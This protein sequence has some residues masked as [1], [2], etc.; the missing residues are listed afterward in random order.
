[1]DKNFYETKE[2]AKKTM[3]SIDKEAL[4]KE[5]EQLYAKLTATFEDKE[6]FRL[7][8]ELLETEIELEK[9]CNQ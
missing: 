7:L 2:D 8:N 6:Q 9:H 4:L 1:M 3:E 5:Q